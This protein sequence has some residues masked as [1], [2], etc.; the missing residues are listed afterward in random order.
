MCC[1]TN[2]TKKTLQQSKYRKISEITYKKTQKNRMT[3]S[4]NHSRKTTMMLSL[5]T[6]SKKSLRKED[7]S[8][9][10]QSMKLQ[11]RTNSPFKRKN[12]KILAKMIKQKISLSSSLIKNKKS[13]ELMT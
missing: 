2:K 11:R 7:R 1:T 5:S 9:F 6:A 13:G 3:S 12:R 8:S 4:L 10:T